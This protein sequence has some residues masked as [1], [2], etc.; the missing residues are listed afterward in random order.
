MTSI[1]TEIKKTLN[2]GPT[3]T[4][5]DTDV[6][7]HINSVFSILSQVGIG[8]ANGFSI[9]DDTATWETFLGSDNPLF[10][11]VKSYM[12]LKV[13]LLFDPPQNSFTIAAYEKLAQEL[14]WRLNVTREGESWTDPTVPVPTP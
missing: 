7:L 3:D 8:P 2:L 4:S 1:L 12:Y 5:F 13:R 14:E 11:N 10:N 6:I 9:V